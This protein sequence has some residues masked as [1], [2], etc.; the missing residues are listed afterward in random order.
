MSG[1]PKGAGNTVKAILT[2]NSWYSV[3]ENRKFAE[4]NTRSVVLRAVR[5]ANPEMR[6]GASV[7]KHVEDEI[8]LK[9]CRG[10]AR[11]ASARKDRAVVIAQELLA[12]M[13]GLGMT[14]SAELLDIVRHK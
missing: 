1:R 4:S 12:V 5:T 13:R 7:L 6:I 10:N 3:A 9:R 11:S 14:A 8:G 2:V